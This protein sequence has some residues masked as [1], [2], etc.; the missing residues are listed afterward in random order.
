MSID[1][2]L[3]S[4]VPPQDRPVVLDE[5]GQREV[6]RAILAAIAVPGHQV[7]FGSREMPVARG[8]G[9]GGLQVTVAIG[10]SQ[11]RI[12]VIDQGDDQG[13][14]AVNLR[15][16]IAGT[17]GAETT[18]DTR[19]CTI[20]QS[21]HRIPEQ[22][23]TDEQVLVLQVPVSEPLRPV[24][25]SIA[26]C[27][28]MHAE[29][30]YSR[31][32]VAMYEDLVT[33]GVVNASSG[34]PV[35]VN[36]RYLMA[37]S[38]IPRWD[39]PRLDQG[40][41]L[42]ILCHGRDKKVYAVP[43]HTSVR[44]ITFDD[45]P[46]EVEYARDQRCIRCGSTDVYLVET[47]EGTYLCSDVEWCARVRTGDVDVA[48]HERQIPRAYYPDPAKRVRGVGIRLQGRSAL[49]HSEH[50]G[51]TAP[52][53]EWALQVTDLVKVFPGRLGSSPVRAVTGVSF[54]VAP[55]EALGVIGESGSGKSTMM[56]CLIGNERATAG[57][58]RL[59]AVDDG[60][61]NVL[62]LD[63]AARRRLRLDVMS[64]VHQDPAAGLDLRISAGGNIADRLT[65]AG[66]R[67]F[68]DIRQRAA[69]LL[70]RVEVPLHRMDDVVGQFSGGM[71]QRVQIARALATDPE[72]LLLDEPTTG[73]DASVAAGVLDLLRELIAEREIAVVVVSHDFQVIQALTDRALVMH[74]GAVIE[75]GLT[76]QLFAD[77]HH[78]YTQRLVAAAHV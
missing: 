47:R 33:G 51:R 50:T 38:P 70:D 7:P 52:G 17:L 61:T 16:L 44:P 54:D 5:Q 34:Y 42:T 32:W 4:A 13:V 64:V 62:D 59:A 18:E 23:M 49:G 1:D 2:V 46:F 27:E 31:I 71:R 30:D 41:R 65:A 35:L 19:D 76:D 58:V 28:R 8:W 53:E 63:D 3:H 72:V 57:T 24:E 36:D 9:S 10:G 67:S 56:N 78:A 66:W 40:D 11:D 43:P 55:G 22:A 21:R 39:V 12:K 15:R 29:A 26:A 77:P 68:W 14:N 45:V 75:Q 73:L 37:P 60:R 20:T 25:K 48:E 69:A 6:R 74:R